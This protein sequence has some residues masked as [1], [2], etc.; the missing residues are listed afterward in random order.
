MYLRVY[1]ILINFHL[2]I[3]GD[4]YAVCRNFCDGQRFGY[5]ENFNFFAM[6]KALGK[7]FAMNKFLPFQ[8]LKKC[9]KVLAKVEAL[10][11]VLSSNI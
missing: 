11:P 8:K 6:A 4:I 5:F 3:V 10:K 7:K 2:F 1:F 9:F